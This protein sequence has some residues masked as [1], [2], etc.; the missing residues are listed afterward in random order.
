MKSFK[1]I[2]S[3]IVLSTS[4]LFTVNVNAGIPVIDAGSIAQAVN[5]LM[6]MKKQYDVMTQQYQ[7]MT[8]QYNTLKNNITGLKLNSAEDIF[9]SSEKLNKIQDLIKSAKTLDAKTTSTQIKTQAEQLQTLFNSQITE[10]N[11]RIQKNNSLIT[12]LKSQLGNA[13]VSDTGKLNTAIQDAYDQNKLELA[14]QKELK[15]S[16]AGSANMMLKKYTASKQRENAT[17]VPQW[18]NVFG[19]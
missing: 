16:Y 14:L 13:N 11:Q 5:Q 17:K 15:E 9:K 10:S 3:V 1:K 2:S 18:K 7:M 8:Q 4:M 6:E 19:S 12:S